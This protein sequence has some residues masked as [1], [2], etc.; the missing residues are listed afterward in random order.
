MTLRVWHEE[1]ENGKPIRVNER[2]PKSKMVFNIM[3]N[4]ERDCLILTKLNPFEEWG[5]LRWEF[6][7]GKE[8]APAQQP[9]I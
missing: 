4:K 8:L 7:I 5:L 3:S 2:V 6:L 1:D 9:S